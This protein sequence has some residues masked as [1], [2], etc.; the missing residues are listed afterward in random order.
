MNEDMGLKS[1]DNLD[2]VIAA[3]DDS[4]IYKYKRSN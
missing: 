1:Y 3:Y 4:A 2:Y